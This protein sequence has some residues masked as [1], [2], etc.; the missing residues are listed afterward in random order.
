M[1]N[2]QFKALAH[3]RPDGRLPFEDKSIVA[4]FVDEVGH[5]S[6]RVSSGLSCVLARVRGPLESRHGEPLE[7]RVVQSPA[8]QFDRR[9]QAEAEKEWRVFV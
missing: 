9:D 3:Y 2:S 8:C 4:E 7:V 1:I 6:V 5:S